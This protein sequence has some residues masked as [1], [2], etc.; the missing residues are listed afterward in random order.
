LGSTPEWR[1]AAALEAWGE[2]EQ[3]LA[4]RL[5]PVARLM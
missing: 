1:A 5:Q 3:P 4:V 2:T